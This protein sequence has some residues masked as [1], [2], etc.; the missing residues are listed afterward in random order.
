M[1]ESL[2]GH[3]IFGETIAMSHCMHRIGLCR[4]EFSW[5]RIRSWDDSIELCTGALSI[6]IS[7]KE[8]GTN[9]YTACSVQTDCA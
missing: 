1:V 4:C 2:I 3:M 6:G 5:I 9:S 7:N 8:R